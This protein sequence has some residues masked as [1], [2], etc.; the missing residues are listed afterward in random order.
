MGGAPIGVR[1]GNPSTKRR[2]S[3]FG[4]EWAEAAESA[5]AAAEI[6][7]DSCCGGRPSRHHVDLEVVNGDSEETMVALAP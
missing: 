1:V 3:F 6:E 2:D 7:M 5:D 4:L